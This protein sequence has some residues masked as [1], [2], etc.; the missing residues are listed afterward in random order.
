MFYD[1]LTPCCVFGLVCYWSFKIEFILIWSTLSHVLRFDLF[2][3]VFGHFLKVNFKVKLFWFVFVIFCR[4]T[5]GLV[6][7]FLVIIGCFQ[8]IC[9]LNWIWLFDR[10]RWLMIMFSLVCMWLLLVK[11]GFSR[12]DLA[13]CGLIRD[14]TMAILFYEQFWPFLF[15]FGIK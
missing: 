13:I 12:S 4:K 14:I 10:I 1:W 7:S 6:L 8:L 11:F 9:M 5:T 3:N 2:L 15:L